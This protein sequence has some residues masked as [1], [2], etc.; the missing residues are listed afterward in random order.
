MP[1][2]TKTGDP[3]S[4]EDPFNIIHTARVRKGKISRLTTEE[5]SWNAFSN[6]P[7]EKKRAKDRE[8]KRRPDK[9]H[10]LLLPLAG[11]GSER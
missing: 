9:L 7:F 8:R 5:I 6:E 11:R 2:T 10:P 4:V 1:R 3:R